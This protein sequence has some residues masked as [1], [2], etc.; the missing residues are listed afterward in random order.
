MVAG[1]SVGQSG[2]D[3]ISVYG[4]ADSRIGAAGDVAV[5]P[6]VSAEML[7][8]P[9]TELES[10]QRRFNILAKILGFAAAVLICW[11]V[12][13]SFSLSRREFGGVFAVRSVCG[14]FV[15]GGVCKRALYLYCCSVCGF[16]V[17]HGGCGTGL[18]AADISFRLLTIPG[19]VV[20]YIVGSQLSNKPRVLD[21]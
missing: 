3:G 18:H 19:Y 14:D 12:L 21:G 15:G 4:D 16:C 10:Q 6:A 5:Q 9:R 8:G 11:A 13:I 1:V 17:I 7:K 20:M 2:R